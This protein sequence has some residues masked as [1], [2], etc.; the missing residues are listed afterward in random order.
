MS[1]EEKSQKDLSTLNHED[2]DNLIKLTKK[3]E[4]SLDDCLETFEPVSTSDYI[5]IIAAIKEKEDL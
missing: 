2:L 1:S 4:Q 5:N 3:E